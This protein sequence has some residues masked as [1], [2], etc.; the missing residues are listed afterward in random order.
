[1]L[2]DYSFFSIFKENQVLVTEF[3]LLTFGAPSRKLKYFYDVGW[4]S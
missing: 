3:F 2:Q 1:M 4:Y